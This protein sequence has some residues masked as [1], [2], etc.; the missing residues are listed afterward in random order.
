MAFSTDYSDVSE[1]TDLLP[2]G[3]Y[4]VIIKYAGEDST[5]APGNKIYISVVCVLRNDV[6]QKYKNK[7]LFHA[8]WHRR[9][10]SPADMAVGGYSSKQ[11]NSMSKAVGIPQNQEFET[12]ADWCE[13]LTN[14][15]MRV[16]TEHDTY[17]GKTR[18][19]IK[20]TN[21]T[22]FPD[23]KHVWKSKDGEETTV[24]NSAQ[25]A[26]TPANFGGADFVEIDG[27]DDLPF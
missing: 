4:E 13:T 7:Y 24:D 26:E 11:I 3:E 9:T 1:G 18:D 21:A 14:R 27:D 15:C 10:P 12:L 25:L 17:N 2:E 20:W 6:D 5:P 23:C 8:L 16:T 19:K 22:Q